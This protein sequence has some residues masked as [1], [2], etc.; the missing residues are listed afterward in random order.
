V[1]M[2]ALCW[3]LQGWLPPAW[4]LFGAFLSLRLC[5]FSYWMNSYWGGAVAGIGGALALGAYPRIGRQGRLAYAW[6]LGIGLG[7][8][9]NTRLYARLLYAIPILIALC[10]HQRSVRLWT[11]LACC[12]ALGAA[13]IL[14]YN[15]RVTGRATRLPQAEYQRQYDYA[16]LFNFLPLEPLKTYR[17]ESFFNLS[18]GW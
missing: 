8:P 6:L 7:I 1:L 14:L 10:F 9:A 2:A 13:F 16:P 5:L 18:H 12:L 11:P 17:H 15:Y 3:T 4:A